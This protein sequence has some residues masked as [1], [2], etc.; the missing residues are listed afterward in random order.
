[1]FRKSGRGGTARAGICYQQK[2]SCRFWSSI[3][4]TPF[5]VIKPSEDT[6]RKRFLI[7][8]KIV[9]RAGNTVSESVSKLKSKKEPKLQK[10]SE[11]TV[12]FTVKYN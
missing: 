11:K 5:T 4:F 7:Y 10:T 6:Q 12:K 3:V 8:I 2:S 9:C 1:M